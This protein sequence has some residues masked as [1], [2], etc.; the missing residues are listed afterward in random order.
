MVFCG[1]V[2]VVL[3]RLEPVA[4]AKPRCEDQEPVFVWAITIAPIVM[5]QKSR[6]RMATLPTFRR[7]CRPPFRAHEDADRMSVKS[8]GA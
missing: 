8:G 6:I 2:I 4:P 5:A 7:S 3:E 1:A